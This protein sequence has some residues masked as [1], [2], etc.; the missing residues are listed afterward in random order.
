M[1]LQNEAFS[2]PCLEELQDRHSQRVESDLPQ[3]SHCRYSIVHDSRSAFLEST[4]STF[5]SSLSSNLR[6][7]NRR[8]VIDCIAKHDH[9]FCLFSS[10]FRSVLVARIGLAVRNVPRRKENLQAECLGILAA[11]V[12]DTSSPCCQVTFV[13][14]CVCISD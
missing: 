6:S 4:S 13:R 2:V 5:S 1:E 3:V 10:C 7:S 12:A 11:S 9:Y 14:V 8:L